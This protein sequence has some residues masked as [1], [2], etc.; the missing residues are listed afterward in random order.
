MTELARFPGSFVPVVLGIYG[1][2]MV[3]GML[4]SGRVIDLATR[5]AAIA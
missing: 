2:G 3:S 4:V 1:V 5:P